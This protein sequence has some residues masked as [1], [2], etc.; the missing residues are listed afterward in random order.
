MAAGLPRG[1]RGRFGDEVG[2]GV[3]RLYML[4]EKDA[5]IGAVYACSHIVHGLILVYEH[6]EKVD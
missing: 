5:G 1:G 4:D 3:S 6:D 2:V